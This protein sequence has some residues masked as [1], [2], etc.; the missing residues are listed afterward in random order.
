MALPIFVLAKLRDLRDGLFIAI[1]NNVQRP[2]VEMDV[3]AVVQAMG[4]VYINNVNLINAV[5]EY[6]SLLAQIPEAETHHGHREMSRCA[7]F[8]AKH[9]RDR[10]CC[11]RLLVESPE[12]AVHY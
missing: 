6:R 5:N 3:L 9:G 12:F 2:L 10:G 1:N 11:F 4:K 8:L 7:D